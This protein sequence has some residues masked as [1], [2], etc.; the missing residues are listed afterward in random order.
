MAD[1]LGKLVGGINK[2]VAT[3]SANSKAMMEKTKINSAISKLEGECKH[4][5]QELGQKVYDT[6]VTTGEVPMGDI[7]RFSTEITEKLNTISHKQDEL[8]RVEEE[9]QKAIE[10]A[11]QAVDEK[12]QEKYDTL[13]PEGIQC[14]CGRI[15]RET[16]K[17]CVGCGNSMQ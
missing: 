11:K 14:E 9:A 15:N 10:A 1:F 5:A 7:E 17:F 12:Y 2:G 8:V 4:L 16:A 3:V 6:Y 13:P